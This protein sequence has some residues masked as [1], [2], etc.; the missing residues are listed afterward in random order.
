MVSTSLTAQEKERV[1]KILT[2]DFM[3]SE[4][5]GSESDSGSEMTRRK[6]F[7]LKPIPWRSPEANGVME[8]LDRKIGRRRSERA[9]EMCRVRR[10]GTPSSRTYPKDCDTSMWAVLEAE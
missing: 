9:R 8:S 3:S 2:L 5:T 10:I 7:L 4:D 6:V 1:M